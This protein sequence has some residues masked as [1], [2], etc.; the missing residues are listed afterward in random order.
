MRTSCLGPCVALGAMLAVLGCREERRIEVYYEDGPY[1]YTVEPVAWGSAAGE[2][3]ADEYAGRSYPEPTAPVTGP[4]EDPQRREIAEPEPR[5]PA[6]DAEWSDSTVVLIDPNSEWDGNT[7]LP[8]EPEPWE[9]ADIDRY[10]Y[11]EPQ[12]TIDAAVTLIEEYV[13]SGG[14]VVLPADQWSQEAEYPESQGTG[15]GTGVILVDPV[16]PVTSTVV[17]H[18]PVVYHHYVW[19]PAPIWVSPYWIG[20]G[21]R[22]WPPDHSIGVH[23]RWTDDFLL[24]LPP[25]GWWNY[26]P[27]WDPWWVATAHYTYFPYYTSGTH[28]SIGFSYGSGIGLWSG[29]DV[30]FWDGG[31]RAGRVGHRRRGHHDGRRDRGG[32]RRAAAPLRSAGTYAS[33]D[34]AAWRRPEPARRAT[35]PSPAWR[36][37]RS[38]ARTD[39]PAERTAPDP[40]ARG[41][42]LRRADADRARSQ[43]RTVARSTAAPSA[44]SPSARISSSALDRLIR[45]RKARTEAM[46]RAA[47]AARTSSSPAAATRTVAAQPRSAQT[48]VS[49]ARSPV[50]TN[51]L[52]RPVAE[53]APTRTAIS[54]A[55]RTTPI[56]VRRYPSR[57]TTSTVRK[58]T[59]AARRLVRPL[60]DKPAPPKPKNPTVRRTTA[61]GTITYTPSPIRRPSPSRSAPSSSRIALPSRSAPI[62]SRAWTPLPPPRPSRPLTLPRTGSRL[63]LP[64]RPSTSI[65]VPRRVSRPVTPAKPT[66]PVTVRRTSRSVS[67]SRSTTVLRRPTAPTRTTT[68]SPTIK[69]PSRSITRPAPT[70]SA[71]AR[72]TSRSRTSLRSR[73]SLLRRPT[74][75]GPATETKK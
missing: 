67:P 73:A 53:R 50:R 40:G 51:R 48:V 64:T 27:G 59:T 29:F 17:L 42:T 41:R 3:V 36:L 12:D 35:S 49:P 7:A 15:Q 66:A 18:S 14:E 26:R 71:P 70:R 65:T 62:R 75:V 45:A 30:G 2:Y 31:W 8:D 19:S 9:I 10:E 6:E 47:T 63:I 44:A 61:S 60:E 22:L 54:S 13:A 32:D 38:T 23:P 16:S 72:T 43:L 57:T 11:A 46:R 58:P 20:P 52:V 25:A 28:L 24:G 1:E 74:S 55:K 21:R 34:G 39:R 68:R 5:Q 4:A 69:A 37:S 56:A 33:R